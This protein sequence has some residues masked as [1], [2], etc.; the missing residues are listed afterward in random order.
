VLPCGLRAGQ[1]GDETP[2]VRRDFRTQVFNGLAQEWTAMVASDGVLHQVLR[3]GACNKTGSEFV[4]GPLRR[5]LGCRGVR[6][7]AANDAQSSFGVA[8]GLDQ[9]SAW[10]ALRHVRG[11]PRG[12][13]PLRSLGIPVDGSFG[14]KCDFFRPQML[15]V[16]HESPI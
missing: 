16:P 13:N 11:R 14:K 1:C 10:S 4:P 2:F 12:I 3:A 7:F 8:V 6:V 9:G 15:V 5:A